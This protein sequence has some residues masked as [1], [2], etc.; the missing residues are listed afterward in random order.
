V[1]RQAAADRRG[2]SMATAAE[3]V[4]GTGVVGHQRA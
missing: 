1:E 2:A 3:S 4:W